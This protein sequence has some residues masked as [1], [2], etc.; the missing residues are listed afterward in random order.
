VKFRAIAVKIILG[1]STG[2]PFVDCSVQC[3]FKKTYRVLCAKVPQMLHLQVSSSLGSK[4]RGVACETMSKA[5]E[6]DDME[7]GVWGNAVVF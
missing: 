4:E 5:L 3:N 2:N 1:V 7:I 6:I